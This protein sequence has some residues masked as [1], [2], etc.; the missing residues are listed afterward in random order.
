MSRN[1]PPS[2][3]GPVAQ[4]NGLARLQGIVESGITDDDLQ[5]IVTA[6]KDKAKAGHEPSARFVID[7]LL[8][9]KQTP[10]TVVV[11][12]FFESESDGGRESASP[13][14]VANI[15]GRSVLERITVYVSAAGAATP[16]VI[17][18][19]I[20]VDETTVIRELDDHPERFTV[21]GNLY[22]L[23]TRV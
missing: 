2:L 8:G 18:S 21:R 15:E 4:T 12:Q 1:K 17:A 14:L 19:Q 7:Y 5:Q 3:T 9:A 10:Q 23:K 11:N 20:G 13:R 6:F 22:S 16:T